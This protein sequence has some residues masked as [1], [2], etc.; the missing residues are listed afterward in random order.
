L[1]G[2]TPAAGKA[3]SAVFH[4]KTAILFAVLET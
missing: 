4:E 2:A 3:G 1:H